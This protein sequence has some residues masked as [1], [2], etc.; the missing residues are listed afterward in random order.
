MLKHFFPTS[1]ASIDTP[2]GHPSID[3]HTAMRK[4]QLIGDADTRHLVK[5]PNKP[6]KTCEQ[7]TTSEQGKICM[8]NWPLAHLSTCYQSGNSSSISEHSLY[9]SVDEN[10]H[11]FDSSMNAVKDGKQINQLQMHLYQQQRLHCIERRLRR[12]LSF[13]TIAGTIVVDTAALVNANQVALLRHSTST[14]TYRR[15]AYY[16]QNQ[17]FAW[18]AQ[19][20]LGQL[21]FP[22]ILG[23]LQQGKLVHINLDRTSFTPVAL[24]ET[25][26][27]AA[28][29]ADSERCQWLSRWPG[30]WLIVPIRKLPTHLSA[31]LSVPTAMATSIEAETSHW[32]LLALSLPKRE[33]W[34]Q[35][36][37][38]AIYG[39]TLEL[40]VALQQSQLYHELVTENQE[41]QKLALADSLTSLANRRRFDQHLVDEWQRLA[42]DQQPLSLVLC[43][44]DYFKLYN[45]TFGH[46]AGDRC[47]IR[48]AR[49]LLTGPQRPADLVARYG[50][51]EFAIILPNT[52]TQ[53]AW[54]IAQKIH[55]S[56]RA[57]K[58]NHA[59][60]H[61]EPYVTL[62]MGVSTII[63]GHNNSPQILVQASDLALYY[64][65]QQGRNRTYINGH[66]NTIHTATNAYIENAEL[67]VMP[68]EL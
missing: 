57:L 50:G 29:V 39:V 24:S 16:C 48:V 54:R 43:D 34:T 52:D 58:I 21:E 60:G 17:T 42:R 63:P 38:L 66:Y 9:A 26:V 19:I 33:A 31:S 40:A 49:A 51:E 2:I 15:I 7:D 44:L 13:S 11:R 10:L 65:K 23:Q 3:N 27:N 36:A 47:L 46:P 62:T 12:T 14:D 6:G 30:N 53:G 25:L 8:S 35:E 59:P 1:H 20:A 5:L 22:G 28:E 61:S 64:A 56:I 41:L 32:G 18:Q 68:A 37:I 67:S 55:N 45:D 4:P